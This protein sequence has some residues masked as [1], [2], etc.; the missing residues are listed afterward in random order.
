MIACRKC[1]KPSHSR[2]LR[3]RKNYTCGDCIKA[4]N[5]NP[6][7]NPNLVEVACAGCGRTVNIRAS[8]IEPCDIYYCQG[9]WKGCK[10][11]P[12]HRLPEVPDGYVGIRTM[13][14]CGSLDGYTV[15]LASL[16][17]LESIARAKA[18]RDAG[19]A[20]IFGTEGYIN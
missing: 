9:S 17:E 20:A 7:S 16:E 12:E 4:A 5:A 19:I 10:R 11:N 18:I 2:R 14:A 6:K 8:K 1:G 13:N 15:R 3:S